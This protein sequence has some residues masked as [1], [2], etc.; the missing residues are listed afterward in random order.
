MVT[1]ANHC[2]YYKK[3]KNCEDKRKGEPRWPS[4]AR[5]LYL[6]IFLAIAADFK[7]L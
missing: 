1:F 7:L 6:I 4:R 3:Q 5:E 2:T